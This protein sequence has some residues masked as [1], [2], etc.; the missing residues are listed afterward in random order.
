MYVID[1]MMPDDFR[2]LLPAKREF[3][4]QSFLKG[5]LDSRVRLHPRFRPKVALL[6]RHNFSLHWF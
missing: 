6:N 2:Q 3:I 5:Y 1:G 4:C